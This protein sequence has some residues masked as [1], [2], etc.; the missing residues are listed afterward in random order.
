MN[1]SWHPEVQT[2][3]L[4][5]DYPAI[6]DFYEQLIETDN[7]SYVDYYYLGL[8]Y[9]LQGK[10]AEA[11]TTWLYIL[12]QVP[13]DTELVKILDTEAQ[14]QENKVNHSLAW[15]LRSHIREINAEHLDN[16]L[17]LIQLEIE[18]KQFHPQKL[19]EWQV[20]QLLANL[21]A[22]S[23][24]S[25]LLFKTLT[26]VLEFH[27][28]QTVDFVRISFP[29]IKDKKILAQTL[30]SVATRMAYQQHQPIYAAEIINLCLPYCLGDFH[31]INKVFNFYCQAREFEKA[32]EFAEMFISYSEV[33]D[34]RLYGHYL[35]FHALLLSCNWKEAQLVAVTYKQLLNQLIV[36]QPKNLSPVV[37]DSLNIVHQLFYFEDNLP[38][39][40]RLHNEVGIL[41][42][43]N[44]VARLNWKNKPKIKHQKKLKI[45][46]IAHTLRSHCVGLLGRWLI[47]YHNREKFEL[48]FYLVNQE[49][50]DITRKW[51]RPKADIF[52]HFPFYPQRIAQQ[53]QDDEIDILVDL[54]GVTSA[55][56]YQ[57]M[58]LKPAPVQ[59]NWLGYDSSGLPT[60]DYVI[61]DPYI[62]PEN[63]Q[64]YYV[65]KIWRLPHT[66][67]AVDGFE[68]GTPTLR[69]EQLDISEDAIIYLN[70]QTGLKG[71]PATIR[72]QM[73]ILKAVTNGYLFFQ[74]FTD[75]A[76][77]KD[78]ILQIA[79]E[80]QIA[81]DRIRFLPIFPIMTYRANLRIVD[82][83]LDTYP[84]NGGTTTLDVLWMGIPVVTRVGQQWPS[85]NGY[86]LMTNAGLSEGIAWTDE[87]YIDWGIRF[88][89]E[90]QLRQ[91]VYQ[92]LRQSRLS[93][94]LWNGYQFT[95][96]MEQAYQQMW[97]N[98]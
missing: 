25:E 20:I 74:G 30:E 47:H 88:G 6:S 93:S 7:D 32:L 75:N 83:I 97:E 91:Q 61:A 26:Q 82:V 58:A 18:L 50:D 12:T 96:E 80:E 39:I 42:Q 84:F 17:Y 72:M 66:Y 14:R 3:L 64:D 59:V 31:L 77:F 19:Q 67:I 38:E 29:H 27:S 98:C 15:L 33:T 60:V 21:P 10:E 55:V 92:K 71:H 34:L 70:V 48:A 90:P 86:A 79:E 54:D 94:P 46:Y 4:R 40:R 73:Q 35:K 23:V 53:I 78:L 62:L 87:E 9:L 24:N 85:R 68:V 44:L 22:E 45:G 5:D 43:K 57:V 69:R 63:A 52:H 49:E 81:T 16:L 89:K 95:Q 1:S 56:N 76:N 28:G 51:F 2:W 36:E 13:E 37:R 8:A 41:F 11:Q 65:E